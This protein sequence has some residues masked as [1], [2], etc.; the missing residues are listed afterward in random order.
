MLKQ[1]L[2]VVAALLCMPA[3]AESVP[4]SAD[5]GRIDPLKQPLARE[6]S[7]PMFTPPP[8]PAAVA[9]P[10]GA[11]QAVF[12]LK[13][14]EFTGVRA[15]SPKELDALYMDKIGEEVTSAY[16]WELANALTQYYR[17]E[18]Y[19]LSRAYV[20]A[21][22]IIDGK[23][24]I[25]AMEGHVSEVVFSD[26]ST[27]RAIISDPIK[28]LIASRPLRTDQ[29]ETFMLTLEDLPGLEYR[30]VIQPSNTQPGSA[31]LVL[32]PQEVANTISWDLNNSGSEFLGPWQQTMAYTRSYHRLHETTLLFSS[33]LQ[34]QELRYAAIRHEL[35]LKSD[36]RLILSG[37]NVS[38]NPGGSL[39]ASD[40]KSRSDELGA[41][42]KWQLLRQRSENLSLGLE[43]NGKNSQGDILGGLPL[44]RDRIRVLRLKANYDSSDRLEGY[45]FLSA[46]L[47]RGLDILGSSEEG[48]ANLSRAEASPDFTTL[49][50][51]YYRMQ[52]LDPDWL[53][54]TQAL[55]QVASGPL[56]S[57]EEFGYG[58]ASYG[59]AYDHSELIGDHGVIGSVELRYR[60][61]KP[62]KSFTF[63]PYAFYDYGHIWNEDRDAQD[64]LAASTGFGVG[65]EHAEGLSASLGV[66]F[67]LNKS[68]ENPLHGNG[69][70]PRLLF[71]LGLNF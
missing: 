31:R 26:Q 45:F 54:I 50:V 71:K 47:T 68:I 51:S 56:F 34:L 60:G 55:G 23:I 28:E 9:S 52:S 53:L 30:A 19:F 6:Q 62:W 48:D 58:G 4:A 64:A 11:D 7:A 63:T 65:L 5:A 66:A 46:A 16:L 2:T 8:P 40:I 29:L 25:A 41:E 10:E 27:P 32:K 17:Q 15:F 33:S 70:N 12:V 57:S 59:R 42:L 67:P 20:P 22:E 44:S 38:A 14:V 1:C 43:L 13:S 18:D 39:E 21:Q 49:N 24:T 37:S 36:L 61:L 69:K 3:Y 35:A